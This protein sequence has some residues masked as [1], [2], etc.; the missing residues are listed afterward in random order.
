MTQTPAPALPARRLRRSRGPPFPPRSLTSAPAPASGRSTFR[1]SSGGSKST[2][3]RSGWCCSASRSARRSPCPRPA[4]LSPGSARASPTAAFGIVNP[5]LLAFAILSGSAAAPLRGR[6]CAGRR[7]RRSRRGDEHAGRGIRDAA[8]GRPLMSSFHAFFSLGALLGSAAAGGAH[9]RSASAT[10]ARPSS[11][12]WQCWRSASFASF[13]LWDSE[14]PPGGRPAP[15]PAAGHPDRPRHRDV[16]GLRGGRRGR[17]LER[18]LPRDRQGLERCRGGLGLHRVFHRDD[19]RAADGRLDRRPP[20][21]GED[22]CRSAAS[23][24]RPDSCS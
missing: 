24:R 17:R 9:R 15:Q 22:A 23:S 20:W 8:R 3:R 14:P 5:F 16:P 21:P 2:R 7:H 10:A 13:F 1:S 18:A 6:L 11:W 19:G 4:R 12:H